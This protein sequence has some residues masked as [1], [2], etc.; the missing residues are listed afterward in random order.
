MEI[1]LD[2]FIIECDKKLDYIDEIIS[3]LKNE[4]SAI[5]NFFEI[6]KLKN[7][8]R[9]VIYTSRNSYKKH[10][11]NYVDE[12]KEWMCGDT[13]DGNINLLDISEARKS[14]EHQDMDLKEFTEVIKHEFVHSCQQ[15]INSNSD[16][17]EWFW[18]ALATNLSGQTFYD[19]DLQQCDF[20]LL[21]DNFTNVSYG[22]PIA[23]KIGKYILKNYSRHQ[24]LEYVKYPNLLKKDCDE[25]FASL[26]ESQSLKFKQ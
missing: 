15:E 22:Y 2:N 26:E 25:I 24:I 17:V 13:Y 8:K 16:G 6:S 10:M 5:L 12:F 14:E 18:E 7:K 4:T 11:L 19:V 9:I 23:Y 21:K 3:I 1:I 20:Q